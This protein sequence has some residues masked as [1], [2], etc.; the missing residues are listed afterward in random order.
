MNV[1]RM[2]NYPCNTQVNKK[3][4]VIRSCPEAWKNANPTI[5]VVFQILSLQPDPMTDGAY[6][7]L[8]PINV[9]ENVFIFKNKSWIQPV[10]KILV[11]AKDTVI[12]IE[13]PAINAKPTDPLVPANDTVVVR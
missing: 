13:D 7:N 10:N 9:S 5:H 6:E 11:Q 3:I 8:R 2:W 12:Q 4:I 1:K